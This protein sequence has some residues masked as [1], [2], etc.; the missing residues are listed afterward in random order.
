LAKKKKE[1]ETKFQNPEPP[2]HK[3]FSMPCYTEKTGGLQSTTRRQLQTC[4]GDTDK[5]DWML[6]V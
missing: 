1:E 2:A 5:Q 6:K 3:N 4:L